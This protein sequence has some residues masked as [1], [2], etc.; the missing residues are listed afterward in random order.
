MLIKRILRYC[1]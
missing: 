1:N